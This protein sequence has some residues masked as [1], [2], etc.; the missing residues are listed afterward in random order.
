MQDELVQRDVRRNRDEEGDGGN[1]QCKRTRQLA[2]PWQLL[3]VSERERES[4]TTR[5]RAYAPSGNDRDCSYAQRSLG[6]K[7]LGGYGWMDGWGRG[8]RREQW[9]PFNFVM[10]P[11]W[12]SSTRRISHTWLQSSSYENKSSLKIFFYILA[13]CFLLTMCRN[14]EILETFKKKIS[15]FKFFIKGN[16]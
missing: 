13:T 9:V 4:P 12:R 16:I 7:C 6:G 15:D 11:H 5:R 8:K 10:L 3:V 2:T 1:R 14:I